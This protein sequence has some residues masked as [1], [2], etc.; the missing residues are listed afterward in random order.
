[1][2]GRRAPKT[3]LGAAL[4][5][6]ANGAKVARVI[7][8]GPAEQAGLAA[9][10]V[11]VAFNGLKATKDVIDKALKWMEVGRQVRLHAFR[12]DELIETTVTLA[13]PE[14]NTVWLELDSDP[15]VGASKLRDEWLVSTNS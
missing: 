11:I 1:M 7:N 9:R 15:T 2:K 12:R 10:D 8:D 6:T 3:T 5:S 4:V 14:A 13:A